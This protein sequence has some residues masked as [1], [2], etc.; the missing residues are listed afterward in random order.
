MS[1]QG[2]NRDIAHCGAGCV[3][4]DDFKL[5][6]PSHAIAFFY[7]TSTL[8]KAKI[9]KLDVSAFGFKDAL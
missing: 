9:S 4:K 8:K 7:T 2:K 5:L 1:H 6:S 3:V